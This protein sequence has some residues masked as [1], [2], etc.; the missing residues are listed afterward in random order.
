MKASAISLHTL[1]FALFC[2]CNISTVQ[3]NAQVTI[4]SDRNPS[5][6][7]L[8]DLKEE[9]ETQRG[10]MLPRV[11][12]LHLQIP[13]NNTDLSLTIKNA[14]DAPWDKDIHTG[15]MV[16]HT[17]NYNKCDPRS[18]PL[19]VY[20]W[21]SNK[22]QHLG[23]KEEEI[24]NS[25]I[26]IYTDSRDGSNYRYRRFDSAGEWMLDNLRYIH[27]EM[28]PGIS[29]NDP[30]VK[31]YTYPKPG[32]NISAPGEIPSN[33]HPQLGLLYTFSSI[34]IGADPSLF[35]GN[36]GQDESEENTNIKIQG[37][38]PEGWHIPSDREWNELE[39][40]IYEQAPLYSSYTT[41]N[42]FPF[43]PPDWDP[44]WETTDAQGMGPRGSDA[45]VTSEGHGTAMLSS[46][47]P[48]ESPLETTGGKSLSSEQGGFN[49]IP[50]GVII[51]GS[52]NNTYGY[53]SYYWTSSVLSSEEA[54]GRYFRLIQVDGYEQGIAQNVVRYV[55]FKE[56]A[57][58][59]SVRCKR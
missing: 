40:V 5:K 7:A 56:N 1:L 11:E 18:F 38:C 48:P 28:T 53:A 47:Q 21:D 14:K 22:W 59:L 4:G 54:E 55:S 49:S 45:G 20:V 17:G 26:K 2:L 16:Y 32:N 9:G 58:M 35:E 51:S 41:G 6:G 8:L 25:E 46:C 50:V 29:N 36:T 57:S 37:I 27:P 39:K 3:L 19:G 15:L 33:W 24:Q 42:G 10:L 23:E 13:N 44:S 43:S 30:T 12:L 52:R 34:A 31:Y